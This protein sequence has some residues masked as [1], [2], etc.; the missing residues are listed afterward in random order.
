MV[1]AELDN[2]HQSQGDADTSAAN[3]YKYGLLSLPP[4][5]LL[6]VYRDCNLMRS[7]DLTKPPPLPQA[8]LLNKYLL[9]GV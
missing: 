2:F 3:P 1:K 5:L 6:T 7:Y 9:P 4:E 8:V